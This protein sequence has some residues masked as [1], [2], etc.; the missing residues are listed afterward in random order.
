M[1][2]IRCYVCT[3]PRLSANKS[4]QLFDLGRY[5]ETIEV[6][7]QLLA[8]SS[9]SIDPDEP[10]VLCMTLLCKQ[11]ALQALERYDDVILI[12]N[13][14]DALVSG[15]PLAEDP[16]LRDGVAAAY[17]GRASALGKLN[18]VDDEIDAY[19]ALFARFGSDKDEHIRESLCGGWLS[20]PQR[21]VQWAGLRMPSR[22]S[23]RSLRFAMQTSRSRS[24]N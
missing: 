19:Q 3:S 10:R 23:T 5:E 16:K 13:Q 12:F 24:R 14:L 4:I 2:S 9:G 1:R 7:D 11:R 15:L 22:C 21:S 18:R 17:A 20:R 6:C 8:R